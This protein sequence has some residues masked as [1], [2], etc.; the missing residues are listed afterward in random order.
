M[1]SS[2]QIFRIAYTNCTYRLHPHK[3]LQLR[4]RKSRLKSPTLQNNGYTRSNV[5]PQRVS[6][7]LVR[8][9]YNITAA[10][11]RAIQ[12]LLVSSTL[13]LHLRMPAKRFPAIHCPLSGLPD[14]RLSLTFPPRHP[15]PRPLLAQDCFGKVKTLS[16]ECLVFPKGFS[17]V[18]NLVF[19]RYE[20]LAKIF[21]FEEQRVEFWLSSRLAKIS[22]S[23]QVFWPLPR[24][25]ILHKGFWTRKNSWA[26][27]VVVSTSP[28]RTAQSHSSAAVAAA[29]RGAFVYLWVDSL[30]PRVSFLDPRH[31]HRLFSLPASRCAFEPAPWRRRRQSPILSLGASS[32]SKQGD[33][34]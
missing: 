13:L 18:Q 31:S 10:L 24:R 29:C 21:P 9:E 5:H 26:P 30:Y 7:R 8:L 33:P 14:R 2:V 25:N 32:G 12:R 1:S 6:G 23:I 19:C 34:R 15:A 22:C 27:A 17:P 16:E 11:A 20:N 3:N 4:V 28:H